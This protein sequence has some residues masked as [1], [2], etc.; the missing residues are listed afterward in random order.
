MTITLALLMIYATTTVPV[1]E[2][3]LTAPAWFLG[4]VKQV[5]QQANGKVSIL[6]RTTAVQ[7][8][9]FQ[10]MHLPPFLVPMGILV[11][12]VITA[13]GQAARVRREQLWTAVDTLLDNVKQV[14]F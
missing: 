3:L 6:Q 14:I 4:N 13:V 12:L 8:L 5:K 1:R 9:A 2:P 10:D 11:L 7:E